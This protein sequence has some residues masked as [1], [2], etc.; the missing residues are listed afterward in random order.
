MSWKECFLKLLGGRASLSRQPA[1][2]EAHSE[3]GGG[4]E[5]DLPH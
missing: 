1:R 3:R 4:K 2:G 5:K